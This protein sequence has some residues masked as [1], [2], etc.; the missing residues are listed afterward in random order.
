M[1]LLSLP[2]DERVANLQE[3]LSCGGAGEL[4]RWVYG[5]DGTLLDT[6]CDELILNTIFSAS[7]CMD[8]MLEYGLENCAPLVLSSAYQLMWCAAFER[9][10]GQL[11]RI[12]VFGPF[13]TA[14]TLSKEI[15]QAISRAKMPRTWVPKLMR[16]LER[17]PAVMANTLFQY[18]LMLHYC[19]S[20]ERLGTGDIMF[21]RTAIPE[22]SRREEPARGDRMQTYMTEQALL[23]MVREGDLNYEKVLGQAASISGGVGISD[24]DALAKTR[25]SAAVFTSLCTRAAIE[26][27]ITPEM[28]YSRGDAYIQDAMGCRTITDLVYINHRMYEDFIRM[29]HKTRTNPKLTKQIQSCCDYI[30]LH[31]EEKITLADLA[32]RIGY[33]EYYLSRKFREETGESINT[34]IKI[35]RVE[36]AKMLLT[37]TQLSI[38]EI[39]ERLCFGTRSFFDDTFKKIV[40]IPPAAYRAQ[41]QRL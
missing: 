17:I 22:E 24:E 2:V 30:E 19:V 8:Y 3:M 16:N 10:E 40:G 37:T 4:I 29:V 13:S 11:V 39:S 15:L 25:I 9:S 20:G 35:V 1:S 36:R 21:Q 12:H 5:P 6:S 38:Q 27:G 26:G 28:A 32:R 34:Y 41:N 14:K 33:A 23:R 18:A 31:A 7:G